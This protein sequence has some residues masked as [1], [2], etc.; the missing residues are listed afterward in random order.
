MKRLSRGGSVCKACCRICRSSG[1]KYVICPILERRV[2][3]GR[4]RNSTRPLRAVAT[5]HLQRLAHCELIPI[6]TRVCFFELRIVNSKFLSNTIAI[7]ACRNVVGTG[8]VP[9]GCCQC[10]VGTLDFLPFAAEASGE[11]TARAGVGRR[12]LDTLDIGSVRHLRQIGVATRPLNHSRMA[13]LIAAVP[14]AEVKSRGSLRMLVSTACIS[15]VLLRA[16][17]VAVN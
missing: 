10:L 6:G 15:G 14:D 7:V 9:R 3:V 2:R 4:R 8:Q 12:Y 11:F 17:D 1:V 16:D 13:I 5:R